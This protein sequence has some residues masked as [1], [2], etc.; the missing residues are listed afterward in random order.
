MP[1]LVEIV[2]AV[3]EK[4]PKMWFVEKKEKKTSP[5]AFSKKIKIKNQNK[6]NK[7]IKI[8]NQNQN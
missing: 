2:Q 1:S 8:K 4:S 5:I 7:K 6:K 3:F